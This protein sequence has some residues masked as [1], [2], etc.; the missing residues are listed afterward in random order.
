MV[1]I[2]D[3]VNDNRPQRCADACEDSLGVFSMGRTPTL[4]IDRFG[5]VR[6]SVGCCDWLKGCAVIF[7]WC[8]TLCAVGRPGGSCG[9]AL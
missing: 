1:K 7:V 8:G 5:C 3:R 6:A 2:I 9:Y 4:V